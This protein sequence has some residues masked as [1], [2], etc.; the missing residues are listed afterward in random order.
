MK[1]IRNIGTKLSDFEEIEKSGK[2]YSFLGK[3]NF[4]YTEKMKSK[5][6]NKIYAIKKQVLN[7]PNFNVDNFYRETEIMLVLNHENIVKLY[8]YFTDKEK[9]DKYKEIYKNNPNI[10]NESIDKDII[11]LVLEYVPN[12][13]LEGYYKQYMEEHKNHYEPIDQNFIIKIYKQL[14]NAL[15]YLGNKSVMHRDIKPDNILL[16]E[17]NNVKITDFGIA[18]LIDDRNP[19]NRNK[20]KRFKYRRRNK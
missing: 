17:N 11:C 5:I 12:G 2:K 4:G 3:G 9:I 18:A 8:G 6:N 16:D 7:N 19:E 13:S 1:F 15:V 10:Q 14:L 20:N